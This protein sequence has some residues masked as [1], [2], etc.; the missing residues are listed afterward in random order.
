[1]VLARYT[2]PKPVKWC[3]LRPAYVG[4]T[5]AALLA[6]VSAEPALAHVDL[7]PRLVERGAVVDV[8]VELPQLAR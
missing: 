2:S 8:R 5:L 4:A 6:I 3:S 7:R 1:M